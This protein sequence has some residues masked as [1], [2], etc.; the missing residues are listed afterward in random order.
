MTR[1][2]FRIAP[3]VPGMRS[4]TTEHTPERDLAEM[5][6]WAAW[7]IRLTSHAASQATDAGIRERLDGATEDAES[8][9]EALA[10][11]ASGWLDE[12]QV[13]ILRSVYDLWDVNH[14]RTER[15]AAVVD[16]IWHRRWRMRSAG[17]RPHTTTAEAA[18]LSVAI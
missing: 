7:V 4:P 5:E 1:V 10:G 14:D 16:P 17:A 18:S 12:G 13:T 2:G 11:A 9:R 6:R 8:L 3:M 15:L